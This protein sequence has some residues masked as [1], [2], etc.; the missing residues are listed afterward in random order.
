M[1]ERP[2]ERLA[3][4]LEQAEHFRRHGEDGSADAALALAERLM[5]RHALGVEDLSAVQRD[6]VRDP[7]TKFVLSFSGIYRQVELLVISKIVN[8]LELG[9]LIMAR[10]HTETNVD[11]L[12]VIVHTSEVERLTAL[13]AS[14]R[15]QL[16]AALARWWKGSASSFGGAT[17][18]TKFKARRQFIMSFGTGVSERI[19]RARATLLGEHPGIE[20][21][22]ASRQR[23]LDQFFAAF[24]THNVQVT[25]RG[26]ALDAATAG[27]EAGLTANTG[28]QPLGVPT[29]TLL[30]T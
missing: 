10:D 22:L 8:A 28:D 20:V 13:L 21:V 14:I 11:E 3:T 23:E 18:M 17:A 1:S 19:E 7:V 27:Y 5:L 26:G 24:D 9:R 16:H 6:D 4:L 25:L 30:E 12:W 29:R 2:L 15:V